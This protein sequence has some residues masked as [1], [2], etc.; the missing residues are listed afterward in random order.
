MKGDGEFITA[1]AY[2]IT[3]WMSGV[4]IAAGPRLRQSHF[5]VM[6][7]SG[8]HARTATA[9]PGVLRCRLRRKHDGRDSWREPSWRW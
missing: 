4:I 1:T 9:G 8:R 3:H 6:S 5:D 7:V 2:M